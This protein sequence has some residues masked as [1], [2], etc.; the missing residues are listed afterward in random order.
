MYFHNVS[1]KTSDIFL[2]NFYKDLSDLSN[3]Y[4]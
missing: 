4:L 2:N 3:I 1:L